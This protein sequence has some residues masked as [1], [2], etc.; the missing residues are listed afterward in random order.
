MC[1]RTPVAA[2]LRYLAS[3]V[4]G[5]TELELLDLLSCNDDAVT[6]A[7][8]Q[9]VV[10]DSRTSQSQSRLLCRFPHR[11]WHD[12]RSELGTYRTTCSHSEQP[13]PAIVHVNLR[14]PVPSYSP[15]GSSV[16]P[17]LIHCS[18][19]SAPQTASRSFFSGLTVVANTSTDTQIERQDIRRNIPRL[20]N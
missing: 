1:G 9:D 10:D 8:S 19:E 5:L 15:G 13:F 3:S 2:A 6:A 11:L 14:S 17:H 20:S 18:R 16:H 4:R 7:M 12:M